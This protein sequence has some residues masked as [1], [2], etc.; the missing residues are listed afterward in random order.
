MKTEKDPLMLIRIDID[1]KKE[2]IIVDKEG[3]VRTVG[4]CWG[5]Q[6][7]KGESVLYLDTKKVVASVNLKEE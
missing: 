6:M 4:I 3:K 2:A 7:E 5:Y 1:P